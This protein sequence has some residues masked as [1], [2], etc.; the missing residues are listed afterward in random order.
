M[1]RAFFITAFPGDQLKNGFPG[2]AAATGGQKC[3]I[4]ENIGGCALACCAFFR[5]ITQQAGE[6]G[7]VV[8]AMAKR[9]KTKLPLG[10]VD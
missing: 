3:R 8:S 10:A 5:G 6:I 7:I 9:M 2:D 1:S 4:E